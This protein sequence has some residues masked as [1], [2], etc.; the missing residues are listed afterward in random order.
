MHMAFL[1]RVFKNLQWYGMTK[2]PA[3]RSRS[4]GFLLYMDSFVSS[5][6]PMHLTC[7]M[8]YAMMIPDEV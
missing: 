8:D 6:C 4:A 2:N 1:S 7:S 3:D 5:E